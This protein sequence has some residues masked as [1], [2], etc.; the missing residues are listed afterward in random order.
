MHSTVA[1]SYSIMSDTDSHFDPEYS[2]SLT[3]RELCNQLRAN[4]P[5]PFRQNSWFINTRFENRCSEAEWVEIFQALKENTSVK[6]TN[7]DVMMLEGDGDFIESSSALVL[8][9]YVESSK[10]LQTLNFFLQ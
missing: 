10:T 1:V 6:H 2:S 3:A 9:E 5:R 7:I 4:N 8:A